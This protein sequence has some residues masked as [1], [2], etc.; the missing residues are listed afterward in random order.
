MFSASKYHTND[1]WDL[2]A[3]KTQSF[4]ASANVTRCYQPSTAIISIIL[5]IK[6]ENNSKAWMR[7]QTIHVQNHRIIEFFGLEGTSSSNTPATGKYNN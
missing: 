6:I 1:L 4:R 5:Y 2:D 7:V 3:E